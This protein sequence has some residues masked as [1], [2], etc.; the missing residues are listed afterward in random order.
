ML[1]MT[2][3]N[4][5]F[6]ASFPR[7]IE[8]EQSIHCINSVRVCVRTLPSHKCNKLNCTIWYHQT[9][10]IKHCL[11]KWN[12][13]NIRSP[14]FSQ[15]VEEISQSLT[16]NSLIDL[17]P[18]ISFNQSGMISGS[19]QPGFWIEI[20]W[21]IKHR[22]WAAKILAVFGCFFAESPKNCENSCG[23]NSRQP[24]KYYAWQSDPE[25]NS[26]GLKLIFRFK[27]TGVFCEQRLK[28]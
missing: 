9:I 21:I 13:K 20:V 3:N 17:N 14:S 5:Q 8:F 27:M 12:S 7:D 23:S 24:S 26:F 19:K 4:K 11:K 16:N 10:S 1:T 28:S 25:V 22:V 18:G 6:K 2:W 15:Q